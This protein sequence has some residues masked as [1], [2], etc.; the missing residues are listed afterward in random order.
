MKNLQHFIS[1][2]ILCLYFSLR[3]IYLG[4]TGDFVTENMISIEGTILRVMEK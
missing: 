4:H 3:Y 2:Q 1:Q